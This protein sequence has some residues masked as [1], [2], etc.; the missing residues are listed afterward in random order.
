[1]STMGRRNVVEAEQR[2]ALEREQ[3]ARSLLES[4][5]E[6]REICAD[7]DYELDVGERVDREGRS[8]E[9]A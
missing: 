7:E 9:D 5:A 6:A 1:M 3:S 2:F 4:L 8:R